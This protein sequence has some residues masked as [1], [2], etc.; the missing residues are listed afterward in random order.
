MA[1]ISNVSSLKPTWYKP[2]SNKD[3]DKRKGGAPSAHTP[4]V[5]S[6]TQVAEPAAAGEHRH[7]DEFA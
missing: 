7:I 4:E 6:E 2:Q 3:R 5:E 1:D